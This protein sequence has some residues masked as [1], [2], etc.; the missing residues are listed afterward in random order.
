MSYNKVVY[1]DKILIDLSS[2][3][4]KE[5]ALLEGYSAHDASGNVISGS[6]NPTRVI[7]IGAKEHIVELPLLDSNG[8]IL[9]DSSG[10]AILSRM[11]YRLASPNDPIQDSNTEPL[12]DSDGD[13]I[14]SSLKV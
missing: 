9:T 7:A 3:T 4:V 14:Y 11:I 13:T 5:D 10:N 6:I 1:G 12:L 8:D 2:D